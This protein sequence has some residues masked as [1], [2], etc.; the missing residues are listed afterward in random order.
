MATILIIEDEAPILTGLEDALLAEGYEVMTAS[1]GE[2]GLKT[3]LQEKTELILLDIMLPKLNGFDLISQFRQ[4]NKTTP[5]IMLTAKGQERDKIK[6]FALGADDYV[7]KPFS[8]KELTARVKAVLKRSLQTAPAVA[9]YVLEGIHFDFKAL[10]AR[11]AQQEIALSPREYDLLR[12]LIEHKGEVISRAQILQA[13]W[14]Y[15]LE[16]TPTTRT[17]DNYIVK[18]RQKVEKKPDQPRHILTVHGKGYRFE[19]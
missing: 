2:L 13:I 7:T 6:G 9:E 17:I 14:Q 10:K 12:Y 5:I 19:E 16:N 11:K 15:D 18:L 3:A 1:N 4:K 8:V